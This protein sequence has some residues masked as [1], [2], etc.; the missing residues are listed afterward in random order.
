M[1]FLPTNALSSSEAHVKEETDCS[2]QQWFWWQQ[3]AVSE[4]S[5]CK[6]HNS[7]LFDDT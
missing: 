2:S 7:L 3:I 6:L 5:V 4:Q 1:E